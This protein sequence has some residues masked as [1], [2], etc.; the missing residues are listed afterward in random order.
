MD[1][2]PQN[3]WPSLRFDVK[4]ASQA[5]RPAFL[6]RVLLQDVHQAPA[7]V[8]RLRDRAAPVLGRRRG[9]AGCPA[10]WLRQALRPSGRAGRGGGPAGMAAAVAAAGPGPGCCWSRRSTTLGG[11][12]RWG[13]G[14]ERPTAPRA[15]RAVAAEGAIEV[16]TNSVVIGRYDDNWVA[17]VQRRLPGAAERLIK[18]RAGTLVVAPG[19]DRA[20]VRLRRQRP[21]RGHAVHRGAPADQPLRG[22]AG[23]ARGGA[24]RQPVRGRRGRRPGP[25]R[26]RGRA[27]RRRAPRRGHR[28]RARARRGQAVELAGGR[29]FDCDLLVTAT[30]WTAPMSLLNDGRGPARST[31][32][33]GPVLPRA[34]LPDRCARDGRHRR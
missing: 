26:G 28:P 29:R 30:G 22:P 8:A 19:P 1:V 12:L 14:L 23:R 10:R 21:A 7:A 2:R 16:L 25:G 32:R 33:G 3:A 5:R 4:A 15:R 31:T 34:G 13:Q 18:A 24:D 9:G 20:A 27:R 11:H 6:R 17:V